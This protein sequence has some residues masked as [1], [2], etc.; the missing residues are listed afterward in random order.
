[1]LNLTNVIRGYPID[2][3]P[4]TKGLATRRSLGGQSYTT[5]LFRPL[6]RWSFKF[7]L[8]QAEK[9]QVIFTLGVLRKSPFII[10]MDYEADDPTYFWVRMTKE[11][12]FTPMIN[13]AYRDSGNYWNWGF[14]IEEAL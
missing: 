8:T 14:E 5:E 12:K 2:L 4:N 10:T 9:D 13:K 7:V 6:R 3:K 1:M 11:D